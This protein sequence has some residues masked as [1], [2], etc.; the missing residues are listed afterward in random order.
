MMNET[1]KQAIEFAKSHKGAQ[2]S[3]EDKTIVI[4]FSSG[5]TEADI[6]EDGML[7]KWFSDNG[8]SISFR[9]GD[10]EYMTKGGWINYRG[11]VRSSGH[12]AYLRNRLIMTATW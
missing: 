6:M 4:P 1:I 3:V 12:V 8:F 2:A 9:T 11:A 5:T 10:V 7:G